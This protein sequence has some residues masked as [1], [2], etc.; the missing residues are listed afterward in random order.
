MTFAQKYL[1]TDKKYLD[2]DFNLRKQ[3][4]NPEL[5]LKIARENILLLKNIFNKNNIKFWLIYGTLLGAVR[6]KDFIKHDFDTDLGLFF[7]DINKLFDIKEQLEEK[8]FKLI[9]TKFPDDLI[10]FMRKDE[11]IDLGFF[12]QKKTFFNNFWIYQNNREKLKYFKSFDEINF[13]G[14]IFLVP[15]NH[16]NFI[17]EH[18]GKNWEIP[19]KNFPQLPNNFFGFKR[20]IKNLLGKS[21]IGKAIIH[22]YKNFFIF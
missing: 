10:T 2:Y 5:N 6:D 15:N 3:R 19:I 20:R 4:R 8:G 18:Y 13:L 14:E 12:S 22:I 21:L 16:I 7:S 9:R 1:G 11:Y 17:E